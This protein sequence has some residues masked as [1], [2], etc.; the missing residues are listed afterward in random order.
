ML[1]VEDEPGVCAIISDILDDAGYDTHCVESDRAAY[2]ILARAR[3]YDAL[4]VDI[5]LGAG[6]TGFDVARFARQMQPDLAVMYVTGQ[7]SPEAFKAFGVPDS[8]FL[9]KPFDAADLVLTL[10][11]LLG[12]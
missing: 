3:R 4:V 5:N 1:V 7:A 2:S 9:P 8:G 12:V 11:T 6:T 10:E